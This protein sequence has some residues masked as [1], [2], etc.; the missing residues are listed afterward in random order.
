M[1]GKWK[2]STGLVRGIRVV[3]LA[4][5][6]PGPGLQ[7]PGPELFQNPASGPLRFRELQRSAKAR[8]GMAGLRVRGY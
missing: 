3:R 4:Q 5:R 1:S 8:P 2:Q 6:D 7:P